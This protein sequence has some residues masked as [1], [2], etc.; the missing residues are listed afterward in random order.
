MALDFPSSPAVGD[1]YTYGTRIWQYNGAAW[2]LAGNINPVGTSTVRTY[3]GDGVTTTFTVSGGL[4]LNDIIVTENGVTQTPVSDY[5]IVGN[6]LTF[7]TAPANNISIVVREFVPSASG[8]GPGGG[9]LN[10]VTRSGLSPT[11]IIVT[12]S[13]L[14]VSTRTG[15]VSISIG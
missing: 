8:L 9:T 11:D 1:S 12:A 14:T 5:D 13:L 15:N 4:R 7:T 6:L 10:I 3:V 2:I